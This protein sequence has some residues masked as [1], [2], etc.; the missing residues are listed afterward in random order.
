MSFIPFIRG[1]VVVI[2]VKGVLFSA[3]IKVA[4]AKMMMDP[5]RLCKIHSILQE[6]NSHQIATYVHKQEGNG[7]IDHHATRTMKMMLIDRNE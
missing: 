3:R 5:I 4:R 2:S 1:V 6:C 7:P